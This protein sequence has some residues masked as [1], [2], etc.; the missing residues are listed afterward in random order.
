[1]TKNELGDILEKR[2]E[3]EKELEDAHRLRFEFYL[4]IRETLIK[5]GQYQFLKIDWEAIEK[6]IK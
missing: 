3:F 5:E 4:N 1:M 2:N 6:E